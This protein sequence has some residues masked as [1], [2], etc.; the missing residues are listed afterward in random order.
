MIVNDH[1]DLFRNLGAD[2]RKLLH[3]A[4]VTGQDSIEWNNLADQLRV[5]LRGVYKPIYPQIPHELEHYLDD[6]DIRRRDDEYRRSQ[7]VMMTSYLL[8]W[9]ARTEPSFRE[10]IVLAGYWLL[11]ILILIVGFLVWRGVTAV[12]L[13][14]IVP[15]ILILT[16]LGERALRLWRRLWRLP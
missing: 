5:K 7:E 1:A 13:L 15:L 3:V 11:F 12:S 16:V 6:S 4:A 8:R 2:L 9:T 14:L 10:R